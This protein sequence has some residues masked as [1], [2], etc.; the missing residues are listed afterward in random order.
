MLSGRSSLLADTT[1][2][3]TGRGRK[4]HAT[5]MTGDKYAARRKREIWGR[6]H[7]KIKAK[8]L[9]VDPK[10]KA[11]FL[12]RFDALRISLQLFYLPL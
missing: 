3:L 9:N 11:I 1:R 8:L 6:I 4:Q 2:W 12:L 5:K 7:S 10:C